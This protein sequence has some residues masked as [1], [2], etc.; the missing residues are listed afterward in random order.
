[1]LDPAQI[2]EEYNL[3]GQ[4]QEIVHLKDLARWNYL[5]PEDWTDLCRRSSDFAGVQD[6]DRLFEA[7]CGSGAF[8]AEVAAYR[9]VGSLAGVDFAE[10][11]VAIAQSRLPGHFQVADI[12]DLSSIP[13]ESYDKVLSHGVFLYLDTEAAALKAAR[14]LVRITKSGGTVYIGI[15][16]DPNRHFEYDAPPSGYFNLSRS[17]WVALAAEGGLA[18]ELLDQDLI[19]SKPSGYDCY[20]RRRY[21]LL[22]RK[23]ISRAL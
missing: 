18:L 10:T 13:S 17:F 6:G 12:T 4:S 16:N 3:L 21:S 23:P 7:G 2:R 14:E 20:S 1:M 22:L 8:L 9:Q 19:F 11:L 15:V 5:S